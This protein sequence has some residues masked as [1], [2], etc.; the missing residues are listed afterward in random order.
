M[1]NCFVCSENKYLIETE[2]EH[3]FCMDCL[4][5]INIDKNDVYDNLCPICSKNIDYTD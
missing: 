3:S 5:N 4:L 1:G 2:C